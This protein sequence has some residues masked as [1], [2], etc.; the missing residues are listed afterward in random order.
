[1][2]VEVTSLYLSALL[3]HR[4]AVQHILTIK[5]RI[6]LTPSDLCRRHTQQSLLGWECS[7]R[8][9]SNLLDW[10]LM[11]LSPSFSLSIWP[12]PLRQ[13]WTVVPTRTQRCPSTHRVGLGPYYAHGSEEKKY[14][15]ARN[16]MDIDI[17]TIEDDVETRDALIMRVDNECLRCRCISRPWK[18]T[19]VDSC[20]YTSGAVRTW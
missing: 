1:M 10:L 12:W 14:S 9:E 5:Y 13:R 11:P 3:V 17:C 18:L 16:D 4:S 7:E 2:R 15:I 6:D 19:V 8:S 20:W